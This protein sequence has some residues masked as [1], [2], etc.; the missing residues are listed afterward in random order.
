MKLNITSE[1][2]YLLDFM[3]SYLNKV[4]IN[5]QVECIINGTNYQGVFEEELQIKKENKDY[6]ILEFTLSEK[7]VKVPISLKNTKARMRGNS[8]FLE[9]ETHV[10]LIEKVKEKPIK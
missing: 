5:E 3:V 9:T 7:K 2:E 1:K 8:V 10:T 4:L 6:Y